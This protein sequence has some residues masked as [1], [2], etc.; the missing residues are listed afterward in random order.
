M[1][2]QFPAYVGKTLKRKGELIRS[3]FVRIDIIMIADSI[4]FNKGFEEGIDK[5][6]L[7][8]SACRHF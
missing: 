6:S 8:I 1:L 4:S 3:Y 7:M 2:G 5:N